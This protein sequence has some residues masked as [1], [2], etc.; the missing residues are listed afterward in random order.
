LKVDYLERLRG[1]YR[2]LMSQ[3][4]KQGTRVIFLSWERFLPEEEVIDK[5]FKRL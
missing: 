3:L 2:R 5:I 1:E 4:Q